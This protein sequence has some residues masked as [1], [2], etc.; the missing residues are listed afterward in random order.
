[1]LQAI[2]ARPFA[3][4]VAVGATAIEK[5]LLETRHERRPRIILFPVRIGG[6]K[7]DIKACLGE[8]LFLDADDHRQVE[9]RVVRGNLDGR[10]ILF[11]LHGSSLALDL[12][13][14]VSGETAEPQV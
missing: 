1:A 4:I 12:K 7:A 6:R 2:D 5:V 13:W 11:G 8:E 3:D 9:Y 14:Q 10:S